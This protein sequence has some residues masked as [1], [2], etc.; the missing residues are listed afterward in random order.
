MRCKWR[1]W[2]KR[3]GERISI[4]IPF[5]SKEP[6]RLLEL[7]WLIAYYKDHLP[8]GTE[9]IV[10]YDKKS[11]RR[12]RTLPFSKAAAVNNAFKRS[13]GDVI[14]VMDADAYVNAD[15]IMHCADRLR[16]QRR[17][18]IRSWFIPYK[19]I[20]RLTLPV[21]EWLLHSS[22]CDP[23]FI[24]D[25]PPKSWVESMDSSGPS[26]GSNYGAM[27]LVMP[28]EAFVEVGGMDP[29]FRGWGG[30]D[31]SF[32][33]ALDTLWGKHRDTPNDLLHLWHYTRKDP[34]PGPNW[35]VRMWNGQAS[36]GV[37]DALASFYRFAYGRPRQMR[38]LCEHRK[39]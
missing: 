7:D 29:R 34:K 13:H 16:A 8:R 2:R 24:P 11:S 39:T 23:H 1:P 31:V 26:S 21:T 38:I 14:V 18:G 35:K 10:G 25:P 9:I 28:R 4:L 37:N 15:V 6:I 32:M 36:P 33:L 17:A 20:Y 5:G 27:L 22:P 19:K 12:A 3:G 30:E